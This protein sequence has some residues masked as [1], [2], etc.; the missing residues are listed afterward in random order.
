MRFTR[1]AAAA[2]SLLML[3]AVTSI[4]AAGAAPTGVGTSKVSTTVLNVALGD[5]GSVLDVKVLDDTAQS[6]I[7]SATN[8]VPLADSKLAAASITSSKVSALNLGVPAPP[9]EAKQPGGTADVSSAA[10]DLANPVGLLGTNVPVPAGLSQVV[11]GTVGLAHLTASAAA[12]SAKSTMANSLANLGV[13]GNLLSASGVSETSA[14]NAT[15][16][17]ADSTREAKI[18]AVTVLDL[19]SLLQ[20]LGI[21]IT[22]L[23]V[24]QVDALLAATQTAVTG[25][26]ANTTLQDTLN[27]VQTEVNTL[28]ADISNLSSTLFT[29]AGI[30][31]IVNNLGLSDVISSTTVT[32]LAGITTTVADQ[33]NA[34]ISAL[35]AGMA[36]L[37]ANALSALDAAPLLK[38]NGV[39]I[40]VATKAADTAANSLA[41]VTATIG[42]VSVG[43]VSLP[44]LNLLQAAA[45]INSAVAT[46]NST[47][48]G[49]LDTVQTTV[50]AQVVS[51]KDLVSVAVLQPTTSVTSSN[52]YIVANAGIT[53]LTAKLTP[54]AQLADLVNA[55]TAQGTAG[56]GIGQVL[57]NT[58][59]N[60]GL[61]APPVTVD[62]SIV[63]LQTTLAA[64]NA[65]LAQGAEVDAVQVLGNSQFKVVAAPTTTGSGGPTLA[66]TGA[67]SARLAALGLL[68][69]ALGLGLARWLDMPVPAFVR[70]R[71]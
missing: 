23:T 50:G 55:I 47:I 62:T 38:L 7:D 1:V 19:S 11:S 56:T 66:A 25:L 16:S 18:D 67:N 60:G 59:A 70:R 46:I 53:A 71:R 3:G 42:G 52:G 41:T 32:S 69:I 39:D 15:S 35:R 14:G 34:V 31:D 21:P 40:S 48:G 57:S 49:A 61:G 5:A 54:P 45:A 8:S 37:L 65:V 28:A 64:A 51:L 17:E 44:G 2:T 27:S 63:D 10:I 43:S 22:D 20:G 36:T 13:A 30:Q 6:T 12:T 68:L 24:G 26:A 4:G 33:Y 9:I 58:V 29:A